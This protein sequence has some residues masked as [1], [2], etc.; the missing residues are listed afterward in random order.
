MPQTNESTIGVMFR[1]ENAPEVLPD[2]ARRAEQ[3]GLS[4]LWVVEDCF[5]GSGIASAAVALACTDNIRVGLGIMPAVARNA[6]FTAMEIATLARI[7]P[8]RFIAGIGHGVGDWMRQIGAFPKSQ[9]AALGETSEVVRRLLAG[10]AVTFHGQHVNLDHV[11]LE[12]PPQTVPPVILGVRG[13]RSLIVSGRSAD[14]TILAEL[15][16]PAY[17][18]WAREQIQQ[19]QNEA[20]RTDEP[21]SITV[22]M[23]CIVD[24]DGKAA[25]QRMR[26]WVADILSYGQPDYI[27]PLGIEAEVN[28]M[29]QNG[30]R[31]RLQA[32]MPD[33]WIEQMSIVG[34]PQ[35]C[36]DSIRRL[37]AAGAESVVLVPEHK[38]ID[39]LDEIAGIL[40]MA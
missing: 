4:E 39:G 25:R 40:G 18:R 1:R 2:Y 3:I 28:A 32:D 30:G 27:R 13:P 34:T 14:G 21:H 36:A 16:S 35:E 33:E 10:E 24:G 26:P 15:A 29:I 31:A 11:K 12:F 37:H 22:Y 20:G 5:Y 38:G 23:L 8:E 19:G 6:A 9:L 17:I 7:Y